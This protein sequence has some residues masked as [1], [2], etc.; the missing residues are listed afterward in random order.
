MYYVLTNKFSFEIAENDLPE[1]M[2]LRDAINV[3]SEIGDRWRL[4]TNE[5]LLLMFRLHQK[6]IGK[7]KHENYWCSTWIKNTVS[8]RSGENFTHPGQRPDPQCWVRLVRN[9]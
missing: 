9:I 2:L 6:A 3:D 4:P 5:E 8:F 7:F 1:K